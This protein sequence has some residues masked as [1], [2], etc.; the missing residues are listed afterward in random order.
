MDSLIVVAQYAVVFVPFP[1]TRRTTL[2]KFGSLRSELEKRPFRAPKDRFWFLQIADSKCRSARRFPLLSLAC[3]LIPNVYGV[4]IGLPGD[5]FRNRRPVPEDANDV[6]HTPVQSPQFSL[7]SDGRHS[8]GLPARSS[9]P[10]RE[11]LRTA[12]DVGP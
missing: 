1:L 10:H 4:R 2:A 7:E 9:K 12:V 8:P 11:S 6:G 5:R 3:P